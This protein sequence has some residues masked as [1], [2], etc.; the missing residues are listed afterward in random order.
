MP[1]RPRVARSRAEKL[2]YHF[3]VFARAI[4]PLKGK[5]IFL[6]GTATALRRTAAGFQKSKIFAKVSSS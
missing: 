4:F 3:F 5:V 1:S 6:R 2:P